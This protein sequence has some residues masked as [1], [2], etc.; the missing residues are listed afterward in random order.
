MLLDSK[1]I[2][3]DSPKNLLTQQFVYYLPA[4]YKISEVISQINLAGYTLN[5]KAM[6]NFK[7]KT[8]ADGN[9]DGDTS[10]A[11]L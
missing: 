5:T 7:F 10:L 8:E 1:Y 9:L 2:K 11:A 3:K 6:E 4:E